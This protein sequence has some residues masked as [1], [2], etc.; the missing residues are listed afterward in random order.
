MY[1]II[2]INLLY[3]VIVHQVGHLARI[4]QGCSVSKTKSLLMRP[5]TN[6]S[7]EK[8]HAAVQTVVIQDVVCFATDP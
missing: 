2:I 4:Q 3:N 8:H 7:Y 6:Y 1:R 5:L